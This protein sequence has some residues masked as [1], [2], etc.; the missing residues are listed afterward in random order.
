MNYPICFCYHPTKI[1][2]IDDNTKY[3]NELTLPL[4]QDISFI[5]F[6]S[7]LKAL[8]FFTHDYHPSTFIQSC[9]K[10]SDD[11]HSPDQLDFKLD[12]R[13]LHLNE[14][15]NNDRFNEIAVVVVDYAMP[16]LNGIE[17][18]RQLKVINP[19]LKIILLTG[20]ADE[21]LAIQAFNE[22]VID[23]YIQ[24]PLE[25]NQR[26]LSPIL[27]LQNSYFYDLTQTLVNKMDK[28]SKKEL[29]WLQ[30][31][32][33]IQL[34]NAFLREKNIVEYYMV[35]MACNFVLADA[36]GNP[37]WFAIVDET[38]M[39]RIYD[40]IEPIQYSEEQ[41]REREARFKLVPGSREPDIPEQII[42]AIKARKKIPFFFSDDDLKV[43]HW[44]WA[45]YLHSAQTLKT[46]Q[47]TYYYTFI[48][49]PSVYEW[50]LEGFESYQHYL[51]ERKR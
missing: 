21:H 14:L 31:S 43:P 45:P 51:N 15:T 12:M 29:Q 1:V 49:Q 48:S 34:F 16:K 25:S 6:N 27:Q 18:S 11:D 9:Y 41:L 47:N 23:Q 38:E 40:E 8:D 28:T 35:D 19:L 7:P 36:S 2:F 37:Y 3:L 42:N 5:T 22:G 33:V 44:D 17:L 24:K 26:L 39:A 46:A 20:E 32:A 13:L 50:P 10:E 4:K 30:D